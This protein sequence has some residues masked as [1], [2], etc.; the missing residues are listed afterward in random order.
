VVVHDQYDPVV[1]DE[2]HCFSLSVEDA[3]ELGKILSN[4]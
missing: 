1:I 3:R 4:L 2:M